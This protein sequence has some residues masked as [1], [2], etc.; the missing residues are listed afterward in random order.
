M[1]SPSQIRYLGSSIQ[2]L[3]E[4]LRAVEE[5]TLAD[6][7]PQAI[8]EKIKVLTKVFMDSISHPQA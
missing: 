7:D 4:I 3:M 8:K 2:I 5:G 1:A 6:I